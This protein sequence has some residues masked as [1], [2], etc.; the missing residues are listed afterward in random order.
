MSS[1]YL[2]CYTGLN[3][4]EE[5]IYNHRFLTWVGQNVFKEVLL[6]G[7][8]IQAKVPSHFGDCALGEDQLYTLPPMEKC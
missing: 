1:F 4:L 7:P 5:S 6:T 8:K 2:E 3:G